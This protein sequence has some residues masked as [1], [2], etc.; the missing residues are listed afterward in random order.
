MKSVCLV[1]S[2]WFACCLSA[3]AQQ[4]L[5]VADVE[6]LLPVAGASVQVKDHTMTTDSLGHFTAPD[7]C[8]TLMLSHVNYESR[9]VNMDELAGDTIFIISKLL[10][11]KEVVVFG[12]GMV[13]DDR[14]KELNQRIR[15]ERT[16]AQLAA[17]DPSKAASIPLGWLAK[18]LP[19]KWRP[20]YK[21][22]MMRKRHEDILR[23]Y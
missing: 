14:L 5:V 2:L 8:R 10:N 23:A 20:G 15:M 11:L 16:E 12:K 18:L 19:K 6:T 1:V 22:E 7:S 9:I 13:V 3:S 4:Q 17:A 21:K